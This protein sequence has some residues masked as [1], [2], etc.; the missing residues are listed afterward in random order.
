MNLVAPIIRFLTTGMT[1]RITSALGL[2]HPAKRLML[3][4]CSTICLGLAFP[5]PS[6]A[7][8]K[9][10]A[11][12]E[13]EW[14]DNKVFNQAAGITKR[15]WLAKC[16]LVRGTKPADAAAPVS[17]PLKKS[18]VNAVCG[19]MDWCQKACGLG[20]QYTCRFGCGLQGCSG[21]CTNCTSRRVSVRT[22]QTVVA[23]TKRPWE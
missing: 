10:L 17:V 5:T 2:D 6:F 13:K 8:K 18:Q 23:N 21:Q 19:G 4:V 15:D 9:S 3:I 14:S 7:Q 11:T 20:G 22:I 16:R 12:C 1:G